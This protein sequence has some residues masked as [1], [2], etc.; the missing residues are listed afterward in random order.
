MNQSFT[1]WKLV[2]SDD[3]SKDDTENICRKLAAEDSR[4]AYIKQEKNIGMFPNFK[5]LINQSRE[6]YFM[7]AAQDDLWDKD[8]INVCVRSL[9]TNINIGLASTCTAEIDSFGR[10]LREI[11]E[12]AL[13]AGKPSIKTVAR[14]ILQPEI[15]GKCNL[16]YGLF[17]TEVL[18]KVWKLYPQ[19][20]VWGQDYMFSLAAVANYE[21][22]ISK[23]VLFKKRQGGFSN[24]LSN[25]NDKL[26]MIR[27]LNISNPKNHIFP[28]GR[29][30]AY[31]KGHMEALQGTPYRPLVALLFIARLPR[32][33]IIHMS[34]RNYRRFLK[35]GFPYKVYRWFRGERKVKWQ[36]SYSQCGEDVIMSFLCN[37]LKIRKPTYLDIGANDPVIMS[38]TYLFYKKGLS[39]VLI[40]PNRELYKKIKRKRDRDIVLNVGVGINNQTCVDFYKMSTHTLST[41][42]KEEALMLQR[43]GSHV[44]KEVVKVELISINEIIEKNFKKSPDIVSIDIE[45]NVLA[46]LE[47]FDFKKNRSA[48]FCIETLTYTEKGTGQKIIEVIDFMKAKNYIVYADTHINTIFVDNNL[49]NPMHSK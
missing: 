1:D 25:K 19:R 23:R 35:K 22:S 21:T 26:E 15:L 34:E 40:E 44:I 48:I 36:K 2:I 6:N 38:N 9:D 46:I 7:W 16:M 49:L 45:G 14:Y 5:F 13:L 11:P 39:G 20:N 12:F 24:P 10:T 37:S 29:F 27:N 31:F 3:C 8:F 32:A 17:R 43:N 4:I 47:S 18:R 41:F 42:S 28:F 30:E 33:F